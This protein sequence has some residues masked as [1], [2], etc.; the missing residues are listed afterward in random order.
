MDSCKD[1]ENCTLPLETIIWESSDSIR[2]REGVFIT[3]LE[4]KAMFMKDNLRQENVM[5]KELFGGA[6]AVGMR[7]NL[8]TVCRADGVS[9][10][11]KVVTDNTKETGIT[12]CLMA[13]VSST[14]K[15]DSDTRALSNKTNSME[16]VYF[17]R[18]TQ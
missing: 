15:T 13:K 3:G 11:V 5:G 10:I 9:Y 6:M 17:T 7:D 1:R 18:M 8:E 12:A 14:L 2:R 4:K 16:T